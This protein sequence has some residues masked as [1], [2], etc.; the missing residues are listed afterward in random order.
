MFNRVN[1]KKQADEIAK[2]AVELSQLY[3]AHT[4]GKYFGSDFG[5]ETTE[6]CAK[7][8]K[9]NFAGRTF[10]AG[11]LGTAEDIRKLNFDHAYITVLQT[12]KFETI[13]DL[14]NTKH[15]SDW[16]NSERCSKKPQ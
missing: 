4:N 8:I 1:K 14:F 9:N 11:F 7:N 12:A 6:A 3:P 16:L 15:T 2:L 10:T 5:P 13:E